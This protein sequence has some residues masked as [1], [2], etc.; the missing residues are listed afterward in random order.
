MA[1]VARR[2]PGWTTPEEEAEKTRAYEDALIARYVEGLPL[3][4]VDRREAVALL[5]ERNARIPARQ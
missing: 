3:T 4:R 2:I 1:S 5:K